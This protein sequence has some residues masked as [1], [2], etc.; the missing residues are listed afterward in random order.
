MEVEIRE[1]VKRGREGKEKKEGTRLFGGVTFISGH[2][3]FQSF[4]FDLQVSSSLF[5]LS[6]HHQHLVFLSLSRDQ[7]PPPPRAASMSST[8]SKWQNPFARTAFPAQD[9]SP[10]FVAGTHA[11]DE[12]TG[13]PAET[14]DRIAR[15]QHMLS[16][17]LGPEYLSTRQGGGGTKLTYIEGWRVIN[18]ANEI[19]GFNGQSLSGLGGDAL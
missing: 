4:S 10:A 2:C 16:K 7:S 18:L 13:R 14:A 11:V 17:K 3:F 12:F 1:G 5:S 15:M 8:P 9:N 19:F 6:P